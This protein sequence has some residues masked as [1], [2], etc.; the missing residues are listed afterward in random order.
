MTKIANYIDGKIIAPVGGNYLDNY[1]PATG[2]VYA[3]IPDS[4]EKDVELAYA[5]AKKAFPGWSTTSKDERSRILLKIADLID[6]N[7]D[8]FALAES[9]YNFKQVKLDKSVDIPR[10]SSNIRFF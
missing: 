1:Q 8:R 9:I 2:K 7:L 10:A 4:D 3:H 5:A 6:Q